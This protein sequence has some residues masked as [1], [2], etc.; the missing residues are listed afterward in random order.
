MLLE[1][2]K[3]GISKKYFIKKQ[4]KYLS[5]SKKD[6]FDSINNEVIDF[7]KTGVIFNKTHSYKSAD[8]L[9]FKD[10]DKL[11]F[12][13]FKS[14][15]SSTDVINFINS[16]CLR[17]KVRDSFEILRN[18]LRENWF[19]HKDKISLFD[20]SKKQFIFSNRNL[21]P[22]L[23]ILLSLEIL[24]FEDLEDNLEVFC[25]DTNEIESYL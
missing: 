14:I 18:I 5:E 22:E 10:I 19:S 1:L 2:E 4:L 21:T 6:G 25:I 3:Y 7:D 23:E 8:A 11:L 9:I 12:I 24:W 17:S 15:E 13:E 20:K 16:L